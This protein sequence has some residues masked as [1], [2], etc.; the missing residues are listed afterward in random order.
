MSKEKK[1]STKGMGESVKYAEGDI[2][3]GKIKG[4]PAWPGKILSHDEASTAVKKEMPQVKKATF[5]LVRFYPTAEFAWLF[6][7]DL[8]KLQKHEI[9]AFINEPHRKSSDLMEG[10]RVALDP[11]EWEENYKKSSEEAAENEAAI[12]EDQLDEDEE[13]EEPEEAPVAS[14]K[15]KRESAAADKKAKKAKLEQLSKRRKSDSKKSADTV[16]SEDDGAADESKVEPSHTAPE[17]AVKAAKPPKGADGEDEGEDHAL[18]HDP[19]A[20]KV[21]DWRH[22]LQKAF[23][24]KIGPTPADMPSADQQLKAVEEYQGYTIEYLQFS[25]IG[26]VM[27]KI[28]GLTEVPRDDEF[29]FK[30]RA[31]ALVSRWQD[32][33]SGAVPKVNGLETLEEP[34]KTEDVEMKDANG[35][36]N[37]EAPTQDEP[38]ETRANDAPQAPDVAPVVEPEPAAA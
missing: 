7:K 22:K 3:L 37:S 27:R 19:E 6:P 32:Q 12:Q 24:G 15:R 29:H 38:A 26:K 20:M 16:E 36:P 31:A 30:D 14:K 35:A 1:N 8:S 10:Y 34:A 21:K 4:Y 23:L 25:K 17:K 13:E 11:T 2:V 28:A 33:L 9:E 5:Y 18:S